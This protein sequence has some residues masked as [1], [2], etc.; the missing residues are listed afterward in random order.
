MGM[1]AWVQKCS[2][3]NISPGNF[4]FW[5]W[6]LHCVLWSLS[7]CLSSFDLL[8]A[9]C[10][11]KLLCQPGSDGVRLLAVKFI[12]AIIL[13]YT[14]DPDVSSDPPNEACE[15]RGELFAFNS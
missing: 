11:I 15:G 9:T 3:P 8:A 12:E 4:C 5:S 13:L 6:L 1:D 10:N 7:L 14:P 2:I